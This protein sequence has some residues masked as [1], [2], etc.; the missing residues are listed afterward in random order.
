MIEETKDMV[1][2][3]FYNTKLTAIKKAMFA[4]SVE[5]NNQIF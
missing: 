2:A 1:S 4:L 3:D 5:K